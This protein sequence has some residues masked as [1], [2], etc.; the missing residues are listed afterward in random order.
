MSYCFFEWDHS[1][2]ISYREELPDWLSAE[3]VAEIPRP[4]FLL[5]ETV[6][7][8]WSNGPLTGRIRRIQA[9]IEVPFTQFSPLKPE[10]VSGCTTIY[11]TVDAGGHQRWFREWMASRAKEGEQV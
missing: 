11:L 6:T 9:Y 2:Q 5:N 10:Q 7:F 1:W 3:A 4:R 8:P